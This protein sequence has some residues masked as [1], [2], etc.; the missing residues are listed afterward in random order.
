M[1][2]SAYTGRFILFNFVFICSLLNVF[3]I[4]DGTNVFLL[5]QNNV[6]VYVLSMYGIFAV[7]SVVS[8]GL[9]R[10]EIILAQLDT[11]N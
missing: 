3:I 5:S 2:I 9:V 4:N 1:L 10:K 6:L 7:V 8:F 11:V